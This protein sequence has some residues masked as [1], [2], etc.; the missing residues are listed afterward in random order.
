MTAAR[1][2]TADPSEGVCRRNAD[3]EK[4]GHGREKFPVCAVRKIKMTGGEIDGEEIV[5]FIHKDMGEP[6]YRAF[7]KSA[8][9]V[10]L[11]S[12]VK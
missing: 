8:G 10:Y 2:E 3:G 7:Y 9:I 5:P 4:I 11:K 1:H 6:T 12:Q